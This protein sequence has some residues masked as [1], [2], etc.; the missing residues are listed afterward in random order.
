M[1][2]TSKFPLGKLLEPT[3]HSVL[4]ILIF[5]KLKWYQKW[6]ED[7]GYRQKQTESEKEE[8]ET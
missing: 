2:K 4:K 5:E 1:K 7:Y 3:C 6:I 8:V